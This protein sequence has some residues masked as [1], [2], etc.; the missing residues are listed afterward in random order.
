MCGAHAQ[1]M[2]AAEVSVGLRVS[3]ITRADV[4][5]ALWEDRSLVK[6]I[7]PRGT[8]HLLAASDLPIWNAALD[9]ALEPPGFAPDVRLSARAGRRGRRSHRRG[10]G[11]DRPDA[12]GARRRGRA[13][14]R[15]LG[16]RAGHARVPGS[17]AAMAAGDPAGCRARRPLLRPEPRVQ[18]HV[19]EPSAVAAGVPVGGTG[20]R[21]D[22]RPASLPVRLRAGPAG[23]PRPVDRQLTAVGEGRVRACRRWRSSASTSKETSSGS[24]AGDADVADDIA[25]SVRLLPYF[26]AY[27]VGSLPARTALPRSCRESAPSPAARPGTTRS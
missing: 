20:R 8:V 6:T 13:T 2:S 3:G 7:G 18:G 10:A 26:D 24:C 5:R 1:V 21:G 15:R 23:A 9:A 11:R 25:G 22:G 12:R 14:G 27:G 19:L 17:L 16:R 4:R